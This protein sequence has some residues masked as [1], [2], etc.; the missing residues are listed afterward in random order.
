MA[1]AL[2]PDPISQIE[3]NLECTVCLEVLKDP[4]TL[5]CCHS[6][7]KDCLEGVVKTCRDEAPRDRPMR[8]I[9]CPTCRAT[10]PLDPE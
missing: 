7:C 5:P 6:F 4:R 10:F 2:A 1:R 8:E 9:P 3:E